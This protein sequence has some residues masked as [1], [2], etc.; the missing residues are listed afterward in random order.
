MSS[1]RVSNTSP[2][3]V[4]IENLG[5]DPMAQNVFGFN[6]VANGNFTNSTRFGTIAYSPDSPY[7]P[8]YHT[9]TYTV[10]LPNNPTSAWVGLSVIGGETTRASLVGAPVSS[11]SPSGAQTDAA[12]TY[13]YIPSDSNTRVASFMAGGT[14][15][16]SYLLD[17]SSISTI[18]N[19]LGSTKK[20]YVQN[21]GRTVQYLPPV[22][23]YT[24]GPNTGI[25]AYYASLAWGY[26]TVQSNNARAVITDMK[27]T[28][29]GGVTYLRIDW[30]QIYNSLGSALP[31]GEGVVI[32]Q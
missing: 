29:V 20:T 17:F 8:D 18:N 30:Q 1:F 16:Y 28:N 14:A 19:T 7:N 22:C 11:F 5:S 4:I 6:S 27:F 12:L 3:S 24:S 15:V 25:G 23:L 31:Y 2:V 32:S 13:Y 21:D 10:A 9:T 26:N